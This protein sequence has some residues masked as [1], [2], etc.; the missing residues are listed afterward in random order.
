M[1][2]KK[3]DFIDE[4]EEFLQNIFHE[5]NMEVDIAV[6]YNKEEQ[7]VDIVLTGEDMGILIGKKRTDTGFT[8]ASGEPC[9]KQTQTKNIFVSSW[10]LRITVKEERKLSSSWQRILPTR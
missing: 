3:S 4:G 10:I 9:Y 1:H 7:V 6:A 8:A 2:V 5:M